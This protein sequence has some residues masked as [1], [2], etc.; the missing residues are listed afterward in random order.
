M[1]NNI[2]LLLMITLPNGSTYV[3]P[4]SYYES[5]NQ[6][7]LKVAQMAGTLNKTGNR[8]KYTCAEV[9]PKVETIDTSMSRCDE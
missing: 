3:A 1:V 4:G 2:M 8:W 7:E 9:A 5:K 6:C